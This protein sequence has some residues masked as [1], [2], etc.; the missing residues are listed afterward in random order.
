MNRKKIA[1]ERIEKLFYFA[2]EEAENENFKK[3]RRYVELA[4]K[5]ATSHNISISKYKRTFCKKCNTYFTSKTVRIRNQK[6]KM[7]ITYICKICD[8][9]QRYPYVKEKLKKRK[10]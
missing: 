9:V 5:I 6:N 1:Q 10:I 8:A 7:V 2:K 4:R 3:S